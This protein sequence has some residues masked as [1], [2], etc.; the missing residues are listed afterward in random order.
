MSQERGVLVIGATLVIVALVVG[1]IL[2]QGNNSITGMAIGVE[3]KGNPGEPGTG[4]VGDDNK[5]WDEDGIPNFA[6]SDDD[7]DGLT[8]V[9]EE[10]LAKLDNAEDSK[11]PISP[12]IAD[13][14]GDGL[15]DATELAGGT[16][17][18][19]DDSD[20]D[21]WTD[22]GERK[23][24]TDPN[25]DEDSPMGITTDNPEG[26]PG[27]TPHPTPTPPPTPSPGP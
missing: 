16:D 18:N 12:N 24:G 20:G 21:G 27:A 1:F 14:D 23:F 15:D 17:P 26:N 4:T 10:E 5:D 7:G 11:V 25:D 8:D 6:D 3:F 9:L 13:S 2:G 22:A 19:N